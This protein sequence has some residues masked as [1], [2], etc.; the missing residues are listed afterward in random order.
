MWRTEIALRVRE[1]RHRLN[2]AANRP[3]GQIDGEGG[4]S[5]A[6]E[7]ANGGDIDVVVSQLAPGE[8]RVDELRFE[9]HADAIEQALRDATAAI[10]PPRRGARIREWW[11]GEAVTAAWEAVHQ[12]EAELIA[13]ESDA[14]NIAML[15]RLRA[16]MRKVLTDRDQ[17]DSYER[18]FD[19]WRRHK[20]PD[21]I[22]LRQ[23]YEDTIGGNL[24]WHCGLRAFRNTI[25]WVAG[26]LMALV[27]GLGLWH[28]LNASVVSLCETAS[29]GETCFGGRR[30]PVPWAVF[31]LELVGAVGGLLSGAFALRALERP[32]ARYDVFAPQL[33]LKAVVGAAAA[34]FGVV[35]MQS[36]ANVD[37][38][39]VLLAYAAVFGFA[40]QLLTR[41]VDQRGADLVKPQ[42]DA[43]DAKAAEGAGT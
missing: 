24:D 16:W 42:S 14:E 32:P 17:L 21:P 41:L 40:Q 8:H 11:T 36:T 4:G 5:M 39:T 12:A 13:I 6:I 37:S 31:E 28:A 38:T 9:H 7:G 34:L 43:R 19:E 10:A 22:V 26:A 20:R 27:V 25:F 33:L 23:A 29:T 2:A 15:P 1:L 30:D 3:P 35:L 18:D